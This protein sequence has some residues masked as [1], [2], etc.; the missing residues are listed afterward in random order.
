MIIVSDTTPLISLMKVN[1]LDL[2][3]KLYG[4]VFI[5]KAVFNELTL[6]RKFATEANVIS[7]AEFITCKEITDITA[8]KIL[9][10]VT[11]LDLG[12]SE[13]IILAQE[14]NADA[15]LMDEAKGR[16]VAEQLGIK[17]SGTLGVLIDGFDVGLL[18]AAEVN[19]C[20]DTLQRYGRRISGDLI[21]FI[22]NYIGQ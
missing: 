15:L 12:E 22:R 5:P 6:N 17:L 4:S 2:L 7:T 20:I 11:L 8:L 18:K 16:K 9:Q 14:L 3:E 13:A 19:E 10:R 1:R 21:K